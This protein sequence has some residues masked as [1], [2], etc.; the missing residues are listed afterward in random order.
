LLVSKNSP[1]PTRLSPFSM[2]L[3]GNNNN[4]DELDT[5]MKL[6]RKNPYLRNCKKV[7]LR[8]DGG[9]NRNYNE[10]HGEVGGA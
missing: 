4:K 8:G 7:E 5:P 1:T 3:H 2:A 10:V 9:N 6:Q